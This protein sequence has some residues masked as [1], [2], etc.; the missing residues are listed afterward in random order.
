MIS[1]VLAHCSLRGKR[2]HFR[3]PSHHKTLF[4]RSTTL[5]SQKLIVAMRNF[6]HV[7]W[8]LWDPL[9]LS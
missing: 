2:N 6:G 4:V 9:P 1:Q 5:I 7:M 8:A 3:G